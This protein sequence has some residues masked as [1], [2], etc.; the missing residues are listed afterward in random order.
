MEFIQKCMNTYGDIT[1]QTL[2][3][4][5]TNA[6]YINIYT[7]GFTQYKNNQRIS[8]IGVYLVIMMNVTSVNL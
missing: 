1:L 7:D 2:I 4:H 5:L 8:G 3:D 6:E